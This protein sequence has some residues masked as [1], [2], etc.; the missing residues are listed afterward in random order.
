[1][2]VGKAFLRINNRKGNLIPTGSQT[3]PTSSPQGVDRSA[4]K[5]YDT[6]DKMGSRLA[7]RVLTATHRDLSAINRVWGCTVYVSIYVT[8]ERKKEHKYTAGVARVSVEQRDSLKKCFS[9]GLRQGKYK[10]KIKL[11]YLIVSSKKMLQI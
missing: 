3:G 11:E 6:A 10:I 8:W 5:L 2:V 9:P 4:S 7:E 1:M